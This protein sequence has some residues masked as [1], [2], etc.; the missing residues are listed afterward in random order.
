M[1]DIRQDKERELAVNKALAAALLV[2]LRSGVKVLIDSG[3]PP[4]IA[5]RVL[6][7]PRHHRASD[8]QR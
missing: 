8:W 5:A 4:R 7:N 6:L 1:D 3:V 2:D